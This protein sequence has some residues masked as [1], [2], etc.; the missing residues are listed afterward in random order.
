M[1]AKKTERKKMNIAVEKEF[2]LKKEEKKP[3]IKRNFSPKN[4]RRNQI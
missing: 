1:H 4:K 3:N 2:F